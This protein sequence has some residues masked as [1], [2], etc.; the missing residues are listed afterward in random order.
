MRGSLDIKVLPTLELLLIVLFINSFG[1]KFT[2]GVLQ[3]N[4]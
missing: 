2:Q 3:C 1:D 4:E